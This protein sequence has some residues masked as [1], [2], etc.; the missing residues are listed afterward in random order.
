[1]SFIISKLDTKQIENALLQGIPS[2]QIITEIKG[3]Q[4]SCD[5]DFELLDKLFMP[6]SISSLDNYNFIADSNRI[7]EIARS[8]DLNPTIGF[9]NAAKECKKHVTPHNLRWI[10]AKSISVFYD[11]TLVGFHS[12]TSDASDLGW[13]SKKFGSYL[14]QKSCSSINVGKAILCLTR[15]SSG[16]AHFLRDVVA[17][18]CWYNHHID[19]LRSVDT[20]ITD[21][22]LS[23]DEI[24]FLHCIG[25]RGQIISTSLMPPHQRFI[26]D[27]VLFEIGNGSLM[28]KD[29]R[30]TI[31]LTGISKS[32]KAV[33]L[34]RGQNARRNLPDESTFASELQKRGI[35]VIN[36][37]G[38]PYLDQLN[39][40]KDYE[41]V[42]SLHGAQLINGILANNLIEIMP[43]PYVL[44]PWSLTIL[45][46]ANAL[47][48]PR[49]EILVKQF[50]HD[51]KYYACSTLL[52]KN[53]LNLSE[54]QYWQCQPS[55]YPK[56]LSS[57]ADLVLSSIV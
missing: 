18:L 19:P 20:L 30:S 17:K 25:F 10:R 46:Q 34:L 33:F 15:H 12:D 43:F 5:A 23:L 6:S 11:R 2:F 49:L 56:S 35:D 44:S 29:L 3:S 8:V 21:N 7:S 9:L 26:G 22:Q 48:I 16:Y 40:A 54:S 53:L 36:T 57:T 39:A 45:K 14:A 31:N 32:K 4:I 50:R 38:L 37:F 52:Y 41:N 24:R 1:M 51:R 27:V 28:L 13:G 47:N 42:V 55:Q